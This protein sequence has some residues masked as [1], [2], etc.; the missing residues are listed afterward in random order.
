MSAGVSVSLAE[1]GPA[2]PGCRVKTPDAVSKLSPT[3]DANDIRIEK[4]LGGAPC[5]KSSRPRTAM[6][7]I[8]PTSYSKRRG[9]D[10]E[11]VR[12]PPLELWN[13]WNSGTAARS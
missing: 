7:R 6:T 13:H 12:T 10:P 8:E 11:L 3:H 2:V 5:A 9:Q 4:S 1:T